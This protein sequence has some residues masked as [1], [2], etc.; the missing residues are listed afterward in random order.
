MDAT[1]ATADCRSNSTGTVL[2]IG[3]GGPLGLECIERLLSSTRYYV[4]ALVRSPAKHTASLEAA[5]GRVLGLQLV[6]GWCLDTLHR[7]PYIPISQYKSTAK[8]LG[9][10]MNQ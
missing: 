6:L 4:R 9:I 8:A 7:V 1:V 5:A 3:A 10:L 2:V